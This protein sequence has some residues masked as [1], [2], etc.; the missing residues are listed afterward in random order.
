MKIYTRTGDEGETGLFGGGRVPKDDVRVEAYGEV[1]ELNA[2]LGVAR[3]VGL[4]PDLERWCASLQEQLFTVGSVLATPLDSKAR[5][6]IPKVNP[7]W[8]SQM[9]QAM[10]AYDGELPALTTFI[11]PAGHAGASALHLSRCV[12][13]RAERRVVGLFRE[14]LVERDVVVYLNRL[15]DFLFTLARVA[16]LRAR[17]SDVPWKPPA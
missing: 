16:N 15:S 8:A 5:G 11:L 12:C 1:D 7:A 2:T 17:V 4:A 9:E 14:S 10:D 3:S 6:H 13:R